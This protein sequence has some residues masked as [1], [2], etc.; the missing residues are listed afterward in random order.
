MGINPDKYQYVIAYGIG[1]NYYKMNSRINLT[2]NYVMDVKW[3]DNLEI[4]EVDGIPVIRRTE[5]QKLTNVLII[6]MPE[7]KQIL[8]QIKEEYAKREGAIDVCHVFD[9]VNGKQTITGT[10][11]R[12]KLPD[13][14]YSD[15]FGNRIEFDE[16]ISDKLTVVFHGNNN[17][18]CIGNNVIV[19][20]ARLICGNNAKI[21]IGNSTSICDANIYSSEALVSIGEDCMLS[22][23]IDI[24]NHDD[25]HI[26]DINSFE[27][28]NFN[29]DVYIG[30]HVWIGK[31]VTLLN[32]CR[33]GDGSIVGENSTTSATFPGNVVIAGSPAKIVRSEVCWSRDN[34]FFF[35]RNYLD[36]CID[37]N[38]KKY[39]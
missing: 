6:V 36:G 4:E 37:Q 27:R 16:S 19:Y 10:E 14:V 34:T 25:H 8:N 11:L 21:I 28:I 15:D 3:E 20:D 39:L 1:Q 33:I 13:C 18:V 32:G 2:I 35:N 9:L 38:A 7:S 31:G 23:N 22:S 26:F 17:S 29:K 24:R 5:L 30:N 12:K